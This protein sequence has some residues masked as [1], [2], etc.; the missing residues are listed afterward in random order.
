MFY[1]RNLFREVNH[2]DISVKYT[3]LLF[4]K[5]ELKTANRNIFLLSL[6]YENIIEK[7][8]LVILHND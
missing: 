4:V 3:H 1:V 7:F 5:S 6:R 2:G 8:S